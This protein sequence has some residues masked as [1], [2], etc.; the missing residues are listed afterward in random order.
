MDLVLLF[1]VVT[2]MM[3][4]GYNLIK[5]T[6]AREDAHSP[7]VYRSSSRHLVYAHVCQRLCQAR[8]M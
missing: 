2:S 5:G 6:A 8:E 1:I 7:F 3:V 4:D